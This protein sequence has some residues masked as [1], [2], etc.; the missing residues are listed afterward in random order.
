MN[1]ET[2]Q[3]I[4]KLRTME[5]RVAQLEAANLSL[6]AADILASVQTTGTWT[7]ALA[8]GGAAVGMTYTTQSG[9]YVRIGALVFYRAR[10]QLSAKG[11]STGAVSISGLP[12]NILDSFG[13][14][15]INSYFANLAS[16]VGAIFGLAAGGTKIISLYMSGSAT[17]AGLT[18]AN[19][20]DTS[21]VDFWG[22]YQA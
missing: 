12:F 6:S 2:R 5:E 4:H 18:E 1:D 11:T 20:T 8:F 19:F 9:L 14:S 21:R 15:L 13:H 16:I 22:V 17:A 7:P 3:L 10:L